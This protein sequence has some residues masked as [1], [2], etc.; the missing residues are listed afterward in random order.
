MLRRIAIAQEAGVPITNYGLLLAAANG[1][2]A[3]P[4]TCMV[5]R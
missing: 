5:I 3:E 2:N 1:I 4:S